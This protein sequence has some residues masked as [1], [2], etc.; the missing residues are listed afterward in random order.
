VCSIGTAAHADPGP[1]G[2]RMTPALTRQRFP[3]TDQPPRMWCIRVK[4]DSQLRVV[5]VEDHH[6][7]L[8]DY[9]A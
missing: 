6:W 3:S 1:G 5:K 7:Q 8:P 2:E 9:W 4:C